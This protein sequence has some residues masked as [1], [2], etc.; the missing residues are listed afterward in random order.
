M[1][2]KIEIY[3]KKDI[4][5]KKGVLLL[6]KGQKL[7]Q[8]IIT[9]LEKIETVLSDGSGNDGPPLPS[10]ESLEQS[11]LKI[12]RGVDPSSLDA[13]DTA[14]DVLGQI[15]FES[16]DKPWWLL[17]QTLSNYIDWV[18]T[19]SINVALLSMIIPQKAGAST[20]ELR[21]ICLG[22]FLHDVGKLLIPK[23]LIQKPGRLDDLQMS[24]VQQ[25]PQLG[26]DIVKE[27]NLPEVCENIIYQHH[28]RLDGSGYPNGLAGDEIS[29]EARI[30]MIADVIDAS[31]SYR[32]YRE[33]KPVQN[34][35]L[36]MRDSPRFDTELVC[37]FSSF[38]TAIK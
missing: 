5:S 36:Q 7:T 33:A 21:E 3:A 32:P 16:K 11:R 24:V 10:R 23:S 35:L 18:Y 37:E 31:T 29:R 2:E 20:A 38:L 1:A 8:E 28:E 9:Q 13:I 6:A 14:A 26:I 25:H 19:H 12:Q 30:V 34:Q 27:Y 4:Y 17:V 15:L 22:A